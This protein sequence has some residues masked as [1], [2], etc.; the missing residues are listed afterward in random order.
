[1]PG[2][3]LDMWPSLKI[4]YSHGAR[5]T[6]GGNFDTVGVSYQYVWLDR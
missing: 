6:I 2:V 1:M 4:A 3:P 5:T